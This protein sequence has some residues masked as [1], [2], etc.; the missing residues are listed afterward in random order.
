[1]NRILSLKGIFTLAFTLFSITFYA[2]DSFGGLA[3]YTVRENMGE[4][5][6]ATLQ[7]VA[8]AGYAYIEA[9]D[10][11][12]GKFYGME[13][14]AFKAYAESLG[15]DPVSAHMGGAT[16]ENADQQIAD[17]KA[18][19]F[20]YF[21]IPVPPMGM[22]TFDRENRTMGMKGTMKEFADIL[23]ILGKKCDAAGLKLLYHN[24]DFEFK[25]NEEGVK[26]IVYLLENTDPKYVN[27]QM[28]LYWVTRAGA[29][30]VG[31]FEEYPGRFKLWHV[32]DMDEEGK[33]AP[34]GE[35]TIDFKRILGEKEAS[36]M[37]KYFVEQ[38]MTWDKKPL[39]VIKISH[40]GLKEIGFK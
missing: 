33:F 27:F 8:D 17:T 29:D 35:G 19:G 5:A 38:D 37:I 7:K 1:M 26:P 16:M 21:T 3:L 36:G 10:Y 30:P 11:K 9:A 13:P 32:K 24:H 15:L 25:D 20:E 6:K 40:K 22:F 28:D 18:A 12:D 34:V 14:Q 31:Y 4:D 23:T 39:E 2:Q